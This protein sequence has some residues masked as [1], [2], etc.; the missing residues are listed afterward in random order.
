MQFEG[1]AVGDRLDQ[2]LEDAVG[3]QDDHGQSGR[4]L[5]PRAA[6]GDQDRE[7]ARGPG[8]D[9]GD[10][11]ADEGDHR[12]RAGEGNG[13]SQMPLDEAADRGSVLEQEEEAERGE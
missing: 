4:G 11:A 8:A 2:L 13:Q 1:R 6:E 12:D 5:G 9:V 10:V 3:Q 7:G